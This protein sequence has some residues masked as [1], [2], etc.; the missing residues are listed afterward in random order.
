MSNQNNN[1][2]SRSYSS[3]REML[4]ELSP[5]ERFDAELRHK[6]VCIVSGIGIYFYMIKI[7]A[8]Y[9][10]TAHLYTD[11]ENDMAILRAVSEFVD[12]NEMIN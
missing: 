2:D 12:T 10:K 6:I 5:V 3:I 8:E 9:E 1:N 4:N 7:L 11:K